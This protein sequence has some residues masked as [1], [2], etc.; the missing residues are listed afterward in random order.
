MSVSNGDICFIKVMYA[1]ILCITPPWTTY[2]SARRGPE[3]EAGGLKGGGD[4]LDTFPPFLEL[5]N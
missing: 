4:F 5:V 2:V 3:C 1:S